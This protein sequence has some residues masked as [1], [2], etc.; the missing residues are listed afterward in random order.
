MKE[1]IFVKKMKENVRMED[2]IRSEFKIAKCG[3]IE[4]QRTPIMTRIVIH[5]TTPGLVIGTGGE[6]IKRVVE[7]LKQKYK[8]ENPQIDIKKIE[9]PDLDP[10]VVAKNIATSIESGVNYKRLGNYFAQKIMDAGATGCE[11]IISGKL[12]GERSR[13]ERFVA[14]YIKKCGEPSER[15]VL[16]GFCLANPKLGNIGVTVKIM[17]RH[18]DV[19]RD[20]QRFMG[21]KKVKEEEPEK[22]EKEEE[23]KKEK[24]K[25]VVA[26]EEPTE[27]LRKEK[28]DTVATAEEKKEEA[29]NEKTESAIEKDKKN[30]PSST[31]EKKK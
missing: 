4:V 18:T 15:D 16:K 21:K 12:S 3:T 27:E 7:L 31:A 17:L 30:K 23:G 28:N 5:T 24:R 14:G 20:L 8:I 19:L 26:K 1:R 6:N 10:Q 2:F 11:I 9:H 13:R 29:K 25:T 22:E